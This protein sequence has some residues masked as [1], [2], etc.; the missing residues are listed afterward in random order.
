VELELRRF[1]SLRA[2]AGA[3]SGFGIFYTRT[4]R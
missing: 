4:L 2:E 1:V 3:V